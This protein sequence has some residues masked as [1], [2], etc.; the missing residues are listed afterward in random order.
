LRVAICWTEISG[1]TAACWRALAARAGVELLITAWPSNLVRSGT[2]FDRSIVSG[3]PVRFLEGV[4]QQDEAKVAALVR[5][6]RPDLIMIG[7]WAER[8]YRRLAWAGAPIDGARFVLAM[9][10][11]WKG[12]MRQRFARVKI[13]RFIDRLDGI[14]VPGERGARFARHLRV[15]DDRIFTGMLGFDYSLFERTLEK[16]LDA[17]PWPRRFVYLG[18]YSVE[19][20]L[21]VMAAAYAEYRAGVRDPWPLVCFGSGPMQHLIEGREGVEVNGWAQ[22]ADQPDILARHGA[23]VLTSRTEAWGIA[24]AEAMAA[25]LPVICTETVGAVP[26]LV[27]AER[28][29]LV[30]RT[31]DVADIA[32]AMR[33][34]HDHYDRLPTMGAFARETAAAYSAENWAARFAGMAERLMNM[35]VRRSR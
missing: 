32:R 16:R 21:D 31:N 23:A 17:G 25:G 11:P 9:D 8:P 13:G 20:A 7:G 34:M 3:L 10:T 18:R 6:H 29:G 4:E 30:A 19:K 15:P 33:W 5:E 27:R 1:Y 12:T 24:V 28:T 22:P 14:F 26:D 35:T 2:Q